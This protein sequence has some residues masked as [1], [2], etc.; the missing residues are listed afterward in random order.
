MTG[1]LYSLNG[2]PASKLPYLDDISISQRHVDSDHDGVAD[3]FDACPNECA[4]GQDAN[5]DGCVDATATLHHVESWAAGALPLHYRIAQGADPL[6]PSA[7]DTAAIRRGFQHWGQAPNTALTMVRD[8]DTAQ[9]N[10]GLDGVNLVTFQDPDF[11]FPA[12]VLAVTPTFS[13]TR[14]A[15]FDD[16]IVLPGQIVDADMIFNPA[17]HFSTPGYAPAFPD[18]FDLE[19]VTTHEAGHFFGLSHSSV[20]RATMFF[21]IQP[22]K[23]A[24][25][26]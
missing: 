2:R 16:Q 4:A 26:L 10:A 19:S 7:G 11:E 1:P 6:N 9:Q 20:L 23:N 25:S 22:G 24:A 12:G 15:M 21:V 18:T 13:F 5:G 8:P 17:A 3:A 14:R